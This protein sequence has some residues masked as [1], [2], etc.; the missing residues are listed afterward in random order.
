[1]IEEAGLLPALRWYAQGFEGRSGIAV[2]L[3]LPDELDRL[4]AEVETAVFRI[5]QEALTN[6]Q[7][8]SGSAVARIRLYKRDNVLHLAIEDEG[9]GMP[10]HL[11]DEERMFAAS[12]VG[13]AGMRERTRELGGSVRIESRDKGT[14]VLMTLPIS[15]A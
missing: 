2:T 14:A 12:G 6:I 5:V 15:R 10:A 7:R 9:R 11:R 1:M 13:I 4:P 8:H 3:D